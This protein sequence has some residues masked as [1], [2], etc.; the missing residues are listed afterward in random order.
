MRDR[1]GK[2]K[3][4]ERRDSDDDQDWVDVQGRLR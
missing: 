3:E 1:E 2:W 4:K